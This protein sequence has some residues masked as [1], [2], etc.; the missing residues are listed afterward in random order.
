[1]YKSEEATDLSDSSSDY[2]LFYKVYLSKEVEE[3]KLF[4]NGNEA[5]FRSVSGGE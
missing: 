2:S 3:V 1:M 4:Q 5:T